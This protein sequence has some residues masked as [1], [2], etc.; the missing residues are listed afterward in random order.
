ML[1][2]FANPQ[3]YPGDQMS[4]TPTAEAQLGFKAAQHSFIGSKYGE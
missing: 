3:L 4:D 2:H 1:G